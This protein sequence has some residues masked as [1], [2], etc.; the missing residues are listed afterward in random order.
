MPLDIIILILYKT[1]QG[2][3]SRTDSRA[4]LNGGRKKFNENVIEM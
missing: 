2:A 1:R 3:D 4:G